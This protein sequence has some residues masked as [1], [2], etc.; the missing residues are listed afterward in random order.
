MALLVKPE[1]DVSLMSKGCPSSSSDS[2]AI[3]TLVVKQR[4]KQ[5][6]PVCVMSR[7]FAGE[8]WG[9]YRI[10]LPKSEGLISLAARASHSY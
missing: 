1:T 10:L 8:T 5:S 6:T 7:Y 4:R 2:A 9:V 3:N